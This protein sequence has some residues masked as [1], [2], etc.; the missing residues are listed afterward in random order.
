MLEMLKKSKKTVG[1]KQTLKAVEEGSAKIV[2]IAKDAD[3][4]VTND[5]AGL[6]QSSSI[7]IE[8]VDTMKLL[9]KA[10]GIQVGAAV[11]AVLD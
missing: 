3:G 8:Y 2:Y 4:K 10:C 9:G 1:V 6:C 11:A 7:R 5:I